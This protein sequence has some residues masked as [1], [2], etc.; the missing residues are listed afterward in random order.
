MLRQ[1]FALCRNLAQ[2]LDAHLALGYFAQC[3]YRRFVARIDLGCVALRQL[4]RAIR[5][6]ERQLE[7]VRNLL[8]AIFNGDAGHGGTFVG[9][10]AILA[11]RSTMVLSDRRYLIPNC[12][13][14][15]RWQTA[16]VLYR[17]RVAVTIAS[18]C[19]SAR[20]KSSLMT[21]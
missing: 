17:S 12:V 5:G 2:H 6:G 3:G 1:W 19:D 20:S 10:G 11:E 13:N 14:S 15:S 18:S 9:C 16:C 21:M 8:Q 4:T 7:A